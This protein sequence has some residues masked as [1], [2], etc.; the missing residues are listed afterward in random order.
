MICYQS[1]VRILYYPK[2][3]LSQSAEAGKK[4]TRFNA[5]IGIA[6]EGNGPMHFKHIQ[7]HFMVMTQRIFIHM[8]HLQENKLYVKHGKKNN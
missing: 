2:G 4:A 1:L 3:I 7:D 6:T 5:T 8:L